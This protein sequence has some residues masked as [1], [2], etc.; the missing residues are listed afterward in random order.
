MASNY[1]PGVCA[2]TIGAPWN[3]EEIEIEFCIN[4]RGL[5][6]LP[7]P[8]NDWNKAEIVHDAKEDVRK[9]ILN[10]LNSKFLDYEFY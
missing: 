6:C 3:D 2:N 7:G 4:V 10:E 5:L 8:I 9:E 1:P